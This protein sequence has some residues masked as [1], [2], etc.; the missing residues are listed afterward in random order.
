MTITTIGLVLLA[1][2]II[3]WLLVTPWGFWL[4]LVGLVVTLV[5]VFSARR[6]RPV[7]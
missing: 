5:G 2:G 4:G 7:V 3:L 1:V 6:D